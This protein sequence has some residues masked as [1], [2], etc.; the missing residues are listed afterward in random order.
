MHC[1]F[2]VYCMLI[3]PI[4]CRW[5]C[6]LDS[7]IAIGRYH[8][9]MT[10]M[11][12]LYIKWDYPS[13]HCPFYLNTTGRIIRWNPMS[14]ILCILS[15]QTHNPS[16]HNVTSRIHYTVSW[17]PMCT[18]HTTSMV[19][20]PSYMLNYPVSS[21]ISGIVHWIPQLVSLLW[22]KYFGCH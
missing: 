19:L 11:L 17:N 22:S 4:H 16:Y 7:H 2:L 18:N 12:G 8:S 13:W 10:L 9:T 1:T 21:W 5:H 14:I 15:S 6:P 20:D 3:C